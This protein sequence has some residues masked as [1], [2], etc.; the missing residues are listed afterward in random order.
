MSIAKKKTTHLPG[1]L[2]RIPAHSVGFVAGCVGGLLLGYVLCQVTLVIVGIN[3]F[4]GTEGQRQWLT[5]ASTAGPAGML[6]IGVLV[7]SLLVR[8]PSVMVAGFA[9]GICS[10]AA[11]Y[12]LIIHAFFVD[13]G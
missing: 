8:R 12:G 5:I 4:S 6:G 13:P 2:N 9:I 7:T 3:S 1:I 11:L 10:V